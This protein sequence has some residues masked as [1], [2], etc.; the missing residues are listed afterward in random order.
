MLDSILNHPRYAPYHGWH[1]DH[2]AADGTPAYLPAMQQVR[3]EFIEFLRVVPERGSC[4]Q[5]GLGE[6][7]ASHA[8]WCSLFAHVVTIDWRACLVNEDSYPGADTRSREAITLAVRYAPY[9]LVFIDAGHSFVDVQH[10]YLHYREMLRPGG[11]VALH[12]ALPRPTYPEVE[13]HKLIAML[14]GVKIIGNEVGI[15]WL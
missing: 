12:D 6:C 2:R 8:V 1:D 3:E 4:L 10:D 15:A 13:V 7:D 5:L 11:I 14:P 9:D